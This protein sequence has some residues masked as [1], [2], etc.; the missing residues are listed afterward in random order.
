MEEWQHS[1]VERFAERLVGVEVDFVKEH[2]RVFCCEFAKLCG[3]TR[4]GQIW[5][6][7]GTRN[8][9]RVNREDSQAYLSM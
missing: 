9:K 3:N 4:D 6:G 1:D 7:L 8:R 2:V 5:M